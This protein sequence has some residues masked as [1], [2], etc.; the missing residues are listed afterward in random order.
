MNFG[1]LKMY[2]DGRL[3]NSVDDMTKNIV[4]PLNEAKIANLSW[5]SAEDSIRALESAEKGFR[6]WSNTPIEKRREWMLLFRS[7]ILDNE[8]IL[9]KSISY[10]MG[11]P[12]AATAEDIESIT[13]SLTYY[14]EIIEDFQKKKRNS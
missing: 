6:L 13:N 10:E 3:V 14:S 7:K 4:S 8:D 12:Y 1:K 2:I 5:G 9:R 11:K